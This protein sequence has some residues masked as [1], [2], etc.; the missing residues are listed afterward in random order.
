M[1]SARTSTCDQFFE[2][3]CTAENITEAEWS[4]SLRKMST[5]RIAVYINRY[6]RL[7]NRSLRVFRDVV[8]ERL[9]L[10]ET[11]AEPVLV[12]ID[13]QLANG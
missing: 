12:E 2:I 11:G 4:E 6:G 5:E 7:S 8:A 10:G 1:S 13:R 9:S 3:E